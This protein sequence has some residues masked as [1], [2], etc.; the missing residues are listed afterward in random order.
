MTR[1]KPLIYLQ[2]KITKKLFITADLP[3]SAVLGEDVC[4]T[5][6][7]YNLL[8]ESVEAWITLKK[9]ASGFRNVLVSQDMNKPSVVMQAYKSV[10]AKTEL[11]TVSRI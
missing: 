3:N 1:S 4:F 9:N 11:G 8:D 6:L 2:L 5:V 10:R 7:A